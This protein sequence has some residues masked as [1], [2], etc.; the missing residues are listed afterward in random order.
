LRRVRAIGLGLAVFLIAAPLLA[1]NTAYRGECKRM[2]RQMAR[3]ERDAKW[4]QQR[5]DAMWREASKD[6]V[7]QLEGRRDELCPHMKKK[8][9]VAKAAEKAAD[10]IAAAAKA[11]APYFIPG[12]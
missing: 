8:N 11:A 3:Y 2:T 6:R 10:L 7:K 9:P 1:A 12:L 5:G 4:A